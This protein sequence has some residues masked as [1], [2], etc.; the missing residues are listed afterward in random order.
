LSTNETPVGYYLD[1]DLKEF[2]KCDEG[3]EKCLRKKECLE[4]DFSKGY[5]QLEELNT[6]SI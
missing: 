5:L 2:A 1:N 6:K 3:C 4:C